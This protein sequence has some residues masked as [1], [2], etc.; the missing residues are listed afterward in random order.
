MQLITVDAKL[1]I[2]VTHPTPLTEEEAGN[3]VFA[4]EMSLNNL[5]TLGLTDG[6][7]VGLRVHA[8]G[9]HLG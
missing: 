1:K 8:N 3:V 9:Y 7:E 5:G 2:R 6:S 4:V